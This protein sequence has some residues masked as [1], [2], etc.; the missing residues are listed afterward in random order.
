MFYQTC[1]DE[2]EETPKFTPP[3]TASNQ[4]SD[5]EN[6]QIS[7]TQK[8][9]VISSQIY[10]KPFVRKTTGI[11]LTKSKERPKSVKNEE[12]KEKRKKELK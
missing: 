7:V 8:N 9:K 1:E 5:T 3:I 6:L 4:D 10:Q 11:Q 2:M 12:K